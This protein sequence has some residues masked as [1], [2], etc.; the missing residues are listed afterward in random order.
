MPF[1]HPPGAYW[2][3]LGSSLELRHTPYDLTAA[4]ERVRATGYPQAEEFAAR[5]ILNPPHEAEMLD[6]FTSVSFR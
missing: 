2:L 4:A 6:A 5:S 1:Q 3:L